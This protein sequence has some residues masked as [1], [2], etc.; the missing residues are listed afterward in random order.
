MCFLKKFVGCPIKNERL[1]NSTQHFVILWL[2]HFFF[3]VT[4]PN[5]FL[6]KTRNVWLCLSCY[7]MCSSIIKKDCLAGI[8]I[9]PLDHSTK[10]ILNKRQLLTKIHSFR[11]YSAFQNTHSTR[12][13]NK[14]SCYHDWY[15]NTSQQFSIVP[16]CSYEGISLS[17]KRL[18]NF[19]NIKFSHFQVD[20]YHVLTK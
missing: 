5:N 8:T 17:E 9:V 13:L 4:A 2:W 20:E 14:S 19:D 11:Q 6:H 1:A 7:H 12:F 16:G 15:I 3:K 10:W 18:R